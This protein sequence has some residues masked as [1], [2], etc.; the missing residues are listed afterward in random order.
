MV[1][2]I[3]TQTRIGLVITA[4]KVRIE[5]DRGILKDREKVIKCH[6]MDKSLSL[7]ALAKLSKGNA[8]KNKGI[9][10]RV[11]ATTA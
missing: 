9:E 1:S 11:V 8:S 4:R 3:P 5:T 7:N 6:A 10:N 2:E